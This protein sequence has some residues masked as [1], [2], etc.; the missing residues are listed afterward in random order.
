[1]VTRLPFSNIA[2][3]SLDIASFTISTTVS[4]LFTVPA[5]AGTASA[6][7]RGEELPDTVRRDERVRGG[8]DNRLGQVLGPP[9][10]VSPPFSR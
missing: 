9:G 5:A 7:V 3:Q 10:K 2:R 8:P 1:M 6:S 4:D